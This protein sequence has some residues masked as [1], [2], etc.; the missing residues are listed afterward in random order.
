MDTSRHTAAIYKQAITTK[1][2]QLEQNPTLELVQNILDLIEEYQEA[3]GKKGAYSDLES[4]LFTMLAPQPVAKPQ[5]SP[6]EINKLET[7]L[8]NLFIHGPYSASEYPS[9]APEVIIE[10]IKHYRTVAKKPDAYEILMNEMLCLLAPKPVPTP[11]P[12]VTIPEEIREV[13]NMHL[14]DT[15]GADGKRIDAY[16]TIVDL[17]TK[18]HKVNGI[19]I[20]QMPTL[21]Q[22][23]WS[24][25]LQ[26]FDPSN[27]CGYYCVFTAEQLANHRSPMARTEFAQEF[28]AMLMA[29]KKMGF[30]TTGRPYENI[31]EDIVMQLLEQ[32]GDSNKIAYISSQL[33]AAFGEFTPLEMLSELA[34]VFGM[35]QQQV[36]LLENFIKGVTNTLTLITRK[37]ESAHYVTM[38]VTR[39]P[40]NTRLMT[41]SIYDSL[42]GDWYSPEDINGVI[43]PLYQFLNQ[44]F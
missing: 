13:V 27:Y 22:A 12:K 3:S 9:Q 34:P 35:P 31:T 24:E 30:T 7:E 39:D 15:R 44:K 4:R 41:F 1:T 37:G 29:V 38:Y 14:T 2:K 8:T 17:V 40:G 20:R 19:I 21:T 43:K 6:Q 10:K 23:R 28:P 42:G 26:G 33:Y 32:R 25:I 11:T 18:D 16:G 5:V 36:T